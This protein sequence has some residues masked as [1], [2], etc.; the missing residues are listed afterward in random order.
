MTFSKALAKSRRGGG[1][2][3]R[4]T[5]VGERLRNKNR[6]TYDQRAISKASTQ[7]SSVR[8]IVPLLIAPAQTD[9]ERKPERGG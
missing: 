3:T 8:Y 5:R 6:E 9:G 4:H 7:A 2:T 1:S